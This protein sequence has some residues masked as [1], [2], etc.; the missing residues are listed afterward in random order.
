M[1]IE[2]SLIQVLDATDAAEEKAEIEVLIGQIPDLAEPMSAEDFIQLGED[3]PIGAELTDEDIIS[4]VN[5]NFAAAEEG[6]EEEEE[7]NDEEIF[8]KP[9]PSRQDAR[10]GLQTALAYFELNSDTFGDFMPQ[11]KKMIC[12]VDEHHVKME[13]QTSILNYF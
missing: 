13:K 1:F 5:G 6:E 11:I 12:K 9:P 2:T 8:E 10:A 3:E 4:F 7:E